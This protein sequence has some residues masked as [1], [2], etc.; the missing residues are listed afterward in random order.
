MKLVFSICINST[1][2]TEHVHRI[3]RARLITV[4]S[5][6]ISYSTV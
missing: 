6:T 2:T 5:K 4:D 1:P 3:R